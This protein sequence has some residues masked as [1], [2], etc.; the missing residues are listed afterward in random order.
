M[1]R[2][3]AI[4]CLNVCCLGVCLPVYAGTTKNNPAY[5]EDPAARKLRMK[6]E[7]LMKKTLKK[8]KKAQDK[9]FKESQKKTH[10]PKHNYQVK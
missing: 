5:R 2:L 6:N 3:A 7:K 4:L 9:M 10:Y 8:Q 1:K